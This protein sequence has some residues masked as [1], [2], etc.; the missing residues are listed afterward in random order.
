MPTIGAVE[1]V[2]ATVSNPSDEAEN[3]TGTDCC[4]IAARGTLES[5]SSGVPDGV[6]SSGVGVPP[7]SESFEHPASELTPVVASIV[8]NCRREIR[9]EGS[10][11]QHGSCHPRMKNLHIKCSSFADE[12]C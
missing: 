12:S 8:A 1:T 11:R 6:A 2:E 3:A 9:L 4:S 5:P 7:V 10:M